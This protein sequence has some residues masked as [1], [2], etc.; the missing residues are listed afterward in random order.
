MAYIHISLDCVGC[1][2]RLLNFFKSKSSEPVKYEKVSSRNKVSSKKLYIAIAST[3]KSD[4]T[5]M[6]KVSIPK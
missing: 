6:D 1:R 3:K 2:D 4:P 5:P